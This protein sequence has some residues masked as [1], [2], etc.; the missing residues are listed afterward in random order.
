MPFFNTGMYLKPMTIDGDDTII[1]GR[2]NTTVGTNNT[3]VDA[4]P[5]TAEDAKQVRKSLPIAISIPGN[6]IT[7]EQSNDESLIVEELFENL[8]LFELME[9]GRSDTVLGQ[10][11]S[12]KPIKNISD[13]YFTYSPKNILALQ[14]TFGENESSAFLKFNQYAV[15][16]AVTLDPAT[17]D[18]VIE[19][20]NVKDGF[21]VQVQ[22]IAAGEIKD[23]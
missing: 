14:G 11:V 5:Q 9:F 16:G 18:L 7:E 17:G 21:V 12:Y 22:L 6:I 8:S 20:E 23:S 1:L 15:D 13:I 10:N 19:V 3:V 4:K 2:N